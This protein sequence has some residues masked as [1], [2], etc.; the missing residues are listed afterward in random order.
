MTRRLL[1][2]LAL[3]VPVAVG[4]AAD[5]IITA[6]GR[7]RGDR[8]TITDEFRDANIRRSRAHRSRAHRTTLTNQQES[9][10]LHALGLAGE[11]GEVCD[12]IK[13]HLFHDKPLDRDK[14]VMEVGDV[15][16]YIDRLLLNLGASIDDA[17]RANIYKLDKRYP[18]G[19]DA[20]DRHFGFTAAEGA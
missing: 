6:R 4:V 17:M 12:E 7:R 11:A 14:I 16:W 2:V 15:L 20:A 5:A 13:K 1:V 10:A 18:D 9:M 19:W 3:V 8:M